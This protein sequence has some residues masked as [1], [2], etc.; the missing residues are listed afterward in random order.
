MAGGVTSHADS[1]TSMEESWYRIESDAVNAMLSAVKPALWSGS[2]KR[3]STCFAGLY[4]LSQESP[5][6]ML[7]RV[8]L[9]TCVFNKMPRDQYLV[10][11]SSLDAILDRNS[12]GTSTRHSCG[13]VRKI[14]KVWAPGLSSRL[15]LDEPCL[16][17]PAEG[18]RGTCPLQLNLCAHSPT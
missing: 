5:R 18:D 7:P 16:R 4:E 13:E 8:I 3:L 9:H 14:W 11:N 17:A 1:R 2:N 15:W 6:V 10:R 12:H